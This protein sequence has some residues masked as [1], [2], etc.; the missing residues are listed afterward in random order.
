M[1]TT[2]EGL[3]VTIPERV[4]IGPNGKDPRVLTREVGPLREQ[5]IAGVLPNEVPVFEVAAEGERL[6]GVRARNTTTEPVGFLSARS[7]TRVYMHDG[8][9]AVEVWTTEVSQHAPFPPGYV[10]V[11]SGKERASVVYGPLPRPNVRGGFDVVWNPDSNTYPAGQATAIGGVLDR[12]EQRIEGLLANDGIRANIDFKFEDLGATSTLLGETEAE[13]IDQQYVNVRNLLNIYVELQDESQTEVN[14]YDALPA[15]GSFNAIFAN[16]QPVAVSTVWVRS[17]IMGKWTLPQP[18]TD[19]VITINKNPAVLWDYDATNGVDADKNDLEE[20]L[21][22]EVIHVLGFSSRVE[23]TADDSVSLWDIFRLVSPPGNF[24]SS[25]RMAQANVEA[26]AVTALNAPSR[27]YRL[28]TGDPGGDGQ[29]SDHWK[30]DALVPPRIGLMDPTNV[31]GHDPALPAGYLTTADLNAVDIFGWNLEPADFDPPPP[32]QKTSPPPDEGHVSLTPTFEWTPGAFANTSNLYIFLGTT[33]S[34]SAEVYRA[35]GLTTGSHTV[36]YG[37][38]EPETIYSWMV[39][40]INEF[41]FASSD[42]RSFTT[43]CYAD[44]D[45]D[46][47]LTLADY[48]CYQTRFATGDPYADCNGDTMLNLADF[49]CFQTAYGQGCH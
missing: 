45:A 44:C 37:T 24:T 2:P 4:E 18:Q 11:L 32:P 8:Q 36:P 48:G 17:T 40:A 49:G 3:F 43:T 7:P 14:L 6:P 1:R 38:V 46:G 34:Q 21:T 29:L 42:G 31:H 26:V 39:T 35:T 41:G 12:V 28:S 33:P 23:E 47:V 27:N 15:S 25:A 9:Y 20:V 30:D 22:H 13:S 16:N 19:A 10:K 5:E